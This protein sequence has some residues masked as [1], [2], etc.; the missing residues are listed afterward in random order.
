VSVV[1]TVLVSARESNLGGR[2]ARELEHRQVQTIGL[3]GGIEPADPQFVDMLRDERVDTV[4]HLTLS[5]EE[6]PAYHGEET[7]Q[8]NII[9]SMVLLGAYARAGVRRV[10]LRS[11]TLIY[12]AHRRNPAFISEDRPPRL[13]SLTGLLREYA[14]I[15]MYAAEFA[16][17][18]PAVEVVRLRCAGLV[19]DGIW[20]PLAHYL[21]RPM[22]R[23]LLGFDPRVQVLH[24]DDAAAAFVLAALGG[25]TGAFNI[26]ANNPLTLVQAVRLTGKQPLPVPGLLLNGR[27]PPGQWRSTSGAWPF[28]ERFLRASCVADIRRAAQKLGWTPRH[29]A[30]DILRSLKTRPPASVEQRVSEPGK[31][32]L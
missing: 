4:V 22:P 18:H 3:P 19:G 29:H 7:L 30:K 21:A 12:G 20:S 9:N 25:A 1:P 15:D 11:S 8:H 31:S 23:L 2:V 13:S 16:R 14:E 6:Q 32:I 17:T 5:G 10:V 26:A 24:P 28:P 27:T